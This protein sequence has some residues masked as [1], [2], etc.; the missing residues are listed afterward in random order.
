MHPTAPENLVLAIEVVYNDNVRSA[1]E[2]FEAY[3]DLFAPAF[4][5]H[6]WGLED[7]GRRCGWAR[8]SL[9][10][11]YNPNDGM[12]VGRR[13]HPL[14]LR[15]VRRPAGASWNGSIRRSPPGPRPGRR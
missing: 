8:A 9:R 14:H 2:R 3:A 4:V 15:A 7:C 6:Y 13:R 1:G 12:E 10:L 11:P 5:F